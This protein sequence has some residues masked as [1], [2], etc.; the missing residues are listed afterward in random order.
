LHERSQLLEFE[1]PLQDNSTAGINFPATLQ[2]SNWGEI[3]PGL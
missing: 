1:V 2:V 3:R